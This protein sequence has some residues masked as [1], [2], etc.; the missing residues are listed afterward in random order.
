MIGA[1]V[2]VSARAA[3]G[4]LSNQRD[5][6]KMNNGRGGDGSAVDSQGRLYVGGGGS[7]DVF[8]PTGQNLGTIVGPQG[9]HGV[10][11]AGPQKRTLYGILAY[12]TAPTRHNE[13]VALKV[14]S[15]GYMGRAK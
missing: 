10:F 12:G 1:P 6:G 15:Q 11:F 4:S 9:L 13:V 14:E 3:D 2:N 5:F 8:S 7:V